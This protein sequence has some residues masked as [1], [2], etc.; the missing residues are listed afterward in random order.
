MATPI[1]AP[2][3]EALQALPSASGAED[4]QTRAESEDSNQVIPDASL[5]PPDISIFG[6]IS[7]MN[8]ETL[9]SSL[10][11]LRDAFFNV[12]KRLRREEL[13]NREHVRARHDMERMLIESGTVLPMPKRGVILDF[14]LPRN[15][16]TAP[17]ATSFKDNSAGFPHRVQDTKKGDRE[18]I[19]EK[20]I[21]L[22][23]KCRLHTI[24]EAPRTEHDLH[25]S[26]SV[27][28]QLSILFAGTNAMVRLSDLHNPPETLFSCSEGALVARM[29]GG[30][31]TFPQFKVKFTSDQTMPK[32]QLFVFRVAPVD[33]HLRS[34]PDLV[35]TTPPFRITARSLSMP[36]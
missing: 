4:A 9:S 18:L 3:S 26:G 23:L 1:Q 11:A 31:V 24:K 32:Q 16:Q 17:S 2:T 14:C 22:H 13:H 30:T 27:Q 8:P 33:A 35:A 12:R 19:V 29:A 7:D 10:T 15:W 20:R 28:F 6:N 25:P 36:R 34:D 21:H 5:T